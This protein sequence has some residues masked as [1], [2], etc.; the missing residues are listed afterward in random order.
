MTLRPCFR[1]LGPPPRQRMFCNVR[2]LSARKT[3]ASGSGRKGVSIC[4]VI[5]CRAMR[6]LQSH[7]EKQK[8]RANERKFLHSFA[9]PSPLRLPSSQES[10]VHIIAVLLPPYK[11]QQEFFYAAT[12]GVL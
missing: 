4:R 8:G 11:R 10:L 5:T 1:Y 9:R 3:A 7:R 2:R 6:F 12:P